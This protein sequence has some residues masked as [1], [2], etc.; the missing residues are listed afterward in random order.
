MFRRVAPY[1]DAKGRGTAYKA[2]IHSTMEYAPLCWMFAS[3]SQ[4]QRLDDIQNRASMIIGGGVKLDTLA[5][6]LTGKSSQHLAMCIV[7]T[8]KVNHS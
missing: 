7:F 6:W 1:L 2:H 3:E 5:A 8:N 4:L